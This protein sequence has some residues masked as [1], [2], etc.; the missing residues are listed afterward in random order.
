M[1]AHPK[2]I[3]TDNRIEIGYFVLTLMRYFVLLVYICFSNQQHDVPYLMD[4]GINA[5]NMHHPNR[6]FYSGTHLKLFILRN[7]TCPGIYTKVIK[8]KFNH[9]PL[10]FSHL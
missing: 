8:Y 5:N 4:A 2:A 9:S 10:S 7:E 3:L 1:G 6:T